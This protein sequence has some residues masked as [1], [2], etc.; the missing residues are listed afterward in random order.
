M[1]IISYN[2]HHCSQAKVDK[3]LATDAD[4][5]IVPELSSKAHIRLPMGY[6]MFWF[7]DKR[8]DKKGLGVIFNIKH[9]CKISDYFNSVYEFILPIKCDDIIILAIW[10]TK[11]ANNKTK[12]YQQI[13][14]EALQEYLKYFGDNK[15]LIC[16]DFNCYVGQPGKHSIEDIFGLLK[17]YD[18]YSIYHSMY[19]EQLGKETSSTFYFRFDISKLFFIDYAFSNFKIEHFEI[20][21]WDRSISDHRALIIQI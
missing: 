4:V 6:D 16:G 14:I 10:P 8:Y 20:A 17:S 3:L 18:I 9:N 21:K 12:S 1:K 13:A 2:I 19:N 15:I 5:F 7:G 11:T